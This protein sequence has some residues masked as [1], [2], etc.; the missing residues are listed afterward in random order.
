MQPSKAPQQYIEFDFPFPFEE[1]PDATRAQDVNVRWVRQHAL[2]R[3]DAAMDWYLRWG[4]ARLAGLLYPYARGVDLDVAADTMAFF[5]L[6]DDQFDGRLGREPKLAAEV[7]R[8]MIGV[9]HEEP[10]RPGRPNGP[11]AE[12]A[13]ASTSSTSRT[14]P[15]PSRSPSR[16]TT[17]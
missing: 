6:F 13:R 9:V 16:G 4:M 2:V 17:P 14:T 7:S 12:A 5:F 1:N 11:A 15:P 8:D 3:S 10:P